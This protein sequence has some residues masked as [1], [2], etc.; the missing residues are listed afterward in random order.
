MRSLRSLQGALPRLL[1]MST[2][3]AMAVE[4]AVDV[5]AAPLTELPHAPYTWMRRTETFTSAAIQPE[6]EGEESVEELQHA[7]SNMSVEV[8]DA[9]IT[10]TLPADVAEIQKIN[11]EL[12][13]A[14]QAHAQFTR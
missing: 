7:L 10:L 13:D 11:P 4:N 12:A 5:V 9:N 1:G 3:G 2:R 14:M 6:Q 8:D